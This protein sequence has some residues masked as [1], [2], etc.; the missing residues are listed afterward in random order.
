MGGS[1]APHARE[2]IAAAIAGPYRAAATEAIRGLTGPAD[3]AT[4][5]ALRTAFGT[6]GSVKVAAAAH[7]AASGD[8][9]AIEWLA[10]EL[11]RGGGVLP[12][13]AM[14]A[15][16][17]TEHS[18]K[19]RDA[20]RGLIWNKNISIRNEGYMLLGQVGAPW[21]VSLLLE[22]LDKEFGEKRVEP[23]VG[24]GRTGDPSAAEAIHPWVETQ[25]LVL[26][27]LEA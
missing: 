14:A 23:I 27:S 5:A 3:E 10:G 11:G 18:E 21:S 22:G 1:T 20:L 15:L 8:A 26:A 13:E 2:A 24:L 16:A 17:T 7:L 6:G 25:G 9:E 12:A 4:Q 19:V